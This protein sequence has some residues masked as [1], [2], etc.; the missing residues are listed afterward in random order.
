[1]VGLYPLMILYSLFIEIPHI[2]YSIIVHYSL[3]IIFVTL[4]SAFPLFNIL[5]LPG[6]KQNYTGILSFRQ[7]MNLFDIRV[8]SGLFSSPFPIISRFL[9]GWFWLLLS[10]LITIYH[11]LL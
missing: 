8:F 6:G 2:P 3:L 1:M 4:L 9:L 11:I 10:S 5:F 7:A